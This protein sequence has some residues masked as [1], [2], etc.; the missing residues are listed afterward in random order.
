MLIC[1]PVYCCCAGRPSR[2]NAR[3]VNS[4]T[5][6]NEE[7][8]IIDIKLFQS[9]VWESQYFQY[10]KWH[11]FHQVD[12]FFDAQQLKVTGS[13]FDDIGMY[14]ID[15]VYSTHSRRMGLTKTYQAGTGN[16]SQNLGHK[17]TIQ[18]EWNRNT[19]QFEGQWY[20]RT[21]NFKGSGDFTLKLNKQQLPI[22]PIYEKV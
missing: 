15:G 22:L 6:Y 16:L 21:R 14:T 12:L 4:A 9:G 20:V 8:Q 11:G 2:S 10:K 3:F 5:K 7:T 13:G 18:L 1:L 19:N 17:V